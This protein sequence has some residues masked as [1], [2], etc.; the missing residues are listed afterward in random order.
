[1]QYV[2][3]GSMPNVTAIARSVAK[4]L[5]QQKLRVVFAESCTG[6]LVS[7]TLAQIPG[8]SEYLCGSA[9]TYRSATKAAWL[10]IDMA[11]LDDPGPVS[12]Q[13]AALMAGS[14]LRRTP[15]ADLAL[16]VTGHLGPNAPA[17][18]DGV[19][20]VGVARRAEKKGSKPAIHV[21]RHRLP[22]ASRVKRQRQAVAIVLEQ[23]ELELEST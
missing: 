11:T 4:L 3:L 14:V 6:G 23:L 12:E 10:K 7:A 13:V 15:E 16:S 8:I 9:V 18:L 21:A 17:K 20:F 2:V 19:V 22:Q 1:M 5:A